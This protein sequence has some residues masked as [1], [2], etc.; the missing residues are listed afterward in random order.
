MAISMKIILAVV[1]VLAAAAVIIVPI[2]L[3]LTK[4][5]DGGTGQREIPG[6][7]VECQPF[8]N[9]VQENCTANGCIWDPVDGAPSC[10]LPASDQ[11]GYVISSQV[12]N[13]TAPRAGFKVDL[14]K[15]GQTLYGN[16]V[17]EIT[18]EVTYFSDQTLGFAIYE[19]GSDPVQQ[20]PPVEITLPS[21]VTNDR[22]YK[23]QLTNSVIG[24]PFNFQIIRQ[25]SNA[26]VFDTA[27][28]GLTFA[29]QFRMITTKLPSGYLYGLGEN[30]HDTF[31]HNM[32]YKM[33]PIFARDQAPDYDDVNLYGAHP[34]YMVSEQDGLSHGAYFF[35]SHAMDVTTMPNPGMTIRTI[36]GNLEFFLFFG[37]SAEEV[38]QQYTSVIGRP[39][40]PAY[41]SLGFQLS[42]W[43]YR[44]TD[45]IRQVINRTRA[46]GI[47]HDVQYAD[48]D[49]MDGNVDFTVDPTHFGDFA[50]LVDTVKEDGLRFVVIIDPAIAANTTYATFNRGNESQVFIKWSADVA[51]PDDQP[52]DNTLLGN[53][54]PAGKTAFPDFFKSSTAQWWTEEIAEFY[55]TI[56]FDGI[57]I[58]MNE[59]ANFDTNV[60]SDKLQCPENPWDDPPYPTMAARIGPKMRLSDRTICMAAKQGE[61][62]QY[63]HYEVHNL[64]GYTESAVTQ[65]AARKVTNARSMVLSRST[66]AGSGQYTGHWLGD[67]FSRWSNLADSIIGIME[68][69]LFGMPYIGADICGFIFNTTEEMCNRWMQLGSFYPFS[70]NHN[71]YDA[72]DQ[73]PGVWPAVADASRRSLMI[74]YRLLPYLYTLFHLSHTTGSTVVR[75]LYHEYPTDLEARQI[76]KQ[77]L[78]GPAFMVTPVVDEGKHDVLAYVPDD[79]WYDYHT[80]ARVAAAGYVTLAAPLGHIN[81]HVRGGYILPAQTP[82]LNTKKSR[83]NNFELL[84]ALKNGTAAGSLFWD[85]GESIDTYESGHYQINYFDMAANKLSNRIERG[86]AWSGIGPQLDLIQVMGLS[87]RPNAITVDAVAIGDERYIFDVNTLLLSIYYTFDMNAEW[88]ILFQ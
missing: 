6:D 5:D 49:Y 54:W 64:Y 25:S 67:N 28:G 52:A 74:R 42:R 57:W 23:V 50:A 11:Y 83:Q 51:I 14:K 48:I 78:W 76:Y 33:W 45:H 20:R 82:A 34:F 55:Q 56:K 75:P 77:F 81:L 84:V 86:P 66:F 18:F 16:D 31:L 72:F 12:V 24:Q 29:D 38:V 58:D 36:G 88:V 79:T 39:F 41:W 80:G 3:E 26:I 27:M 43:G 69:N 17:E 85:D 2:S 30:T 65:S 15:S 53:V 68:F 44:D 1:G 37:P 87:T 46:A 22:Q 13:L 73:D 9:L 10:F 62:D 40:M 35:N 61:D 71:I 4:S 19:K 59:P 47:P 21:G 32:N 7:R 63:Y 8:N 60:Y 70:R